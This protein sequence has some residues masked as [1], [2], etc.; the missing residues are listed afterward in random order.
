MSGI[1][2]AVLLSEVAAAVIG[3]VLLKHAMERSQHSAF[4]SRQVLPLFVASVAALAVSFFLMLALLQHFELSYFF[5]FQAST[6]IVIVAAAV[7][8]LR[9]RL[10]LQLVLG[11]ALIT[12][13]IIIV[14][15]S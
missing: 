12:L 5:P 8:I 6:T 9:E 14:S 15:N 2:L 13:G 7:T 4:V 3:Q 11:T 1:A 10:S